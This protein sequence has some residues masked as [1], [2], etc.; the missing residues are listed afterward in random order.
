[1]AKCTIKGKSDSV[2]LHKLVKTVPKYSTRG[3]FNRESFKKLGIKND[4]VL[5]T[6]V[7]TAN[8]SLAR[9]TWRKYGYTTAK[10]TRVGKEFGIDMSFPFDQ[11]KTLLFIYY[12]I[13]SL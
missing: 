10:V 13:Q 2:G 8:G 5:K 11:T 7:S 9:S 3:G 1:M 4:V 6:L 12:F